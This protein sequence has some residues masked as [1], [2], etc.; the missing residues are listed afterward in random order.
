MDKKRILPIIGAAFC[1]LGVFLAYR[2][3]TS[4]D[5]DSNALGVIFPIALGIWLIIGPSLKDAD[6]K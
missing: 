3:L 2:E 5:Q 1:L 6:K 4:E